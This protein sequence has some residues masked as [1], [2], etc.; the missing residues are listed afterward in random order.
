MSGAL[1]LLLGL[2]VAEIVSIVV[3]ADLIGAL[4]TILALVAGAAGGIAVIRKAGGDA[5]RELRRE[6]SAGVVD[7]RV[8]AGASRLVLIGVL[9]I[10]PGFVSDV[11]ALALTLPPVR[12]FLSRGL[13]MRTTVVHA[14]TTRQPRPGVVE[15]EREEFRRVDEKK[16]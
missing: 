1:I 7:A 5:M 8:F 14:S 4:W 13:A 6:A 16:G 12:R 10:V 15:L 9:L 2:P 3:A 11:F